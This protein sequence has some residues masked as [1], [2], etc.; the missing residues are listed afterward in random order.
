MGYLTE[1]EDFSFLAI[2]KEKKVSAGSAVV[3]K[4]AAV[5]LQYTR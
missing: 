1:N 5:P 3:I 4:T 2:P